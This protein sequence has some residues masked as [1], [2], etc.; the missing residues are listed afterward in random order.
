MLSESYTLLDWTT[1]I[2]TVNVNQQ[3]TPTDLNDAGLSWKVL[4]AAAPVSSGTLTV[5]LSNQNGQV[6]ADA[7]RLQR[8]GDLPTSNTPEVELIA[9]NGIPLPSGAAF[10]VGTGYAGQAYDATFT[11]ANLGT[12]SLTLANLGVSGNFGLLSTFGNS[13]LAA[14]QSTTFTVQQGTDVTGDATGGLSFTT[15]DSTASNYHL[16]FRVRL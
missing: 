8:V 5:Q 13:A 2:G 3:V 15:N 16:F 9:P 11:V 7:I 4:M 1:T 6:T 14:G 10:N 12:A